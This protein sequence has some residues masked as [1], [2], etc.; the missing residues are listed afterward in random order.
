MLDRKKLI[1]EFN[2]EEKK[3]VIYC[4]I[5]GGLREPDNYRYLPCRGAHLNTDKKHIVGSDKSLLRATKI[6]VPL[7]NSGVNRRWSRKI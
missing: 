2:W 7:S 5:D 6:R 3:S 4:S 1:S